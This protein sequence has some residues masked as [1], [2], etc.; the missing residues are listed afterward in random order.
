MQPTNMSGQ[1]FLRLTE[2][3]LPTHD[4]WGRLARLSAPGRCRPCGP[5]L[6][7]LGLFIADLRDGGP[8][9]PGREHEA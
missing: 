4:L 9:E 3:R 8:G 7:A 6:A 1:S 2:L 5:A